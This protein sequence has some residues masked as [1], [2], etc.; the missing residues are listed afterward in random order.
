MSR[1]RFDDAERERIR[2]ALIESGR[3]LFAR[4][5]LKKTTVAELTDAVGI[6]DGT[7]YRFF[8][9]KLDLYVTVLEREGEAMRPRVL[10]PLEAEED[11]EAAIAAFLRGLMDEIETD[12]I[13]RRLLVERDDLER[14]RA[15]YA[16]EGDGDRRE[17][18]VAP[19]LPT[20][21]TWYDAGRLRGP[22]PETAAHALRAVTMLTLHRRDIGEERYRAVRDLLI[23]AVAAGLTGE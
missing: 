12:P 10:A 9:S 17:E 6:A 21:R 15:Y 1:G 13:V 2:G 11:P 18:D 3:E 22:D 8:D 20:V 19:Y 7:F 16:T 14:L 23:D 5:G 4:Y